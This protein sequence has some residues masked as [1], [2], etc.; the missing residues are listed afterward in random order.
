MCRHKTIEWLWHI[1]LLGLQISTQRSS[2]TTSHLLKKKLQNFILEA[3]FCHNQNLHQPKLHTITMVVTTEYKFLFLIRVFFIMLYIQSL[4][5]INSKNIQ[6]CLNRQ[7]INQKLT[8]CLKK[9][10]QKYYHQPQHP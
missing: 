4:I 8:H 9:K 10:R 5:E 2:C 1:F 7:N 6:G 3:K